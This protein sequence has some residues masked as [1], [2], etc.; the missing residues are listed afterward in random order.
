MTVER[1]LSD[2]KAAGMNSMP[3]GG[4]EIFNAAVRAEVCPAKISGERWIDIHK[5]AHRLGLKTNATMLYGHVESYADRVDHLLRLRDAQ[6]ETGGF[7][8]F[9]PLA[10]QPK[11]NA[12]SHL[13]ATTGTDDLKTLAIARLLLDNFD[14]IKAY[15]VMTG[16]KIAQVA[17]F[18][19][20]NDMDGTVVEE[21]ISLMSQAGH[22]QEMPKAE[23][24][25]VIRDA[26]RNPVER[27]ALYRVVRRFD[28]ASEAHVVTVR[29]G[30]IRFLNCYPMY[31]GLEQRGHLGGEA[32][33]DRPG[34]P[35]IDLVPGVPTELN[36][37]LVG[38]QIDLGLISS[39]AYARDFRRL[40]ISRRVSISSFGAVDSIQL[41][42]RRPLKDIR[43]VALTTQSATSVALLK[44]MFKLRFEQDVAYGDL[45]GSVAQALEEY[46]AALVIGDQGLEALY[47]PEPNTTCHDLGAMWMDWTRLPMVYAV[48]AAR[49]EFA[50]AN[51]PELM[52]VE[53]ELI[54]CRDYGRDHLPDVVESALG[55]YRFERE[56][57][58][59]YFA[60]LYYGFRDEYQKGLRRFY[61]LAYEAGE[62]EEMPEL[63][64]IDEVAGT[65][66]G[67]G[68][69]AE[70]AFGA[71]AGLPATVAADA[72]G[73]ATAGAAP[74]SSAAPA[75]EAA[76]S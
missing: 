5:T 36:D 72:A 35:G 71:A 26:G 54:E 49:E 11:N 12:L 20:A 18:F 69:G 2:L 39:I 27:D 66:T 52:E 55:R 1:L 10:F 31:C 76:P 28:G 67:P 34:R 65:G 44:T 70:A 30:H 14:H 3:G 32:P 4:A 58:M 25:R 16:L 48:W 45:L 7:Q 51:G 53:Q 40:V 60:L 47:F 57:L 43:S 22:G 61:E 63:R 68:A 6:D 41:V 29:M 33:V 19:G 73:A 50:R 74:T 59:R 37:W 64:F 46:D 62:L 42:T 17:L 23:L 8:A 56:A 9:I 15:W 24:V 75:T 13:P 21:V 38:G